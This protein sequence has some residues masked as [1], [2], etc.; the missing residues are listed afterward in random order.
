MRRIVL[1][2]SGITVF[3]CAPLPPVAFLPGADVEPPVITGLRLLSA[4]ELEVSFN[5]P[6][7]LVSGPRHP[8]SVALEEAVVEA[9]VLL[10]RFAEPP[11]PEHEHYVEAQVSDVAGNNLRFVV[12]FYGLNTLLPAMLI[13]EFITKHS[14]NHGEFVE[15]RIL[16]DG[17]LAGATL[18]EGI[19]GDWDQRFIF[20]SVDVVAGDYVVVHFRPQG[21]PEEV[22]E[23]VDR[24]ISGGRNASPDAWDFWVNGGTGLS[25]NNGVLTLCENPLG[26]YIDAVLYSNRTSDSD[27]RYRGFGSTRLMERADAIVTAGAW[28]AS[29]VTA[30]PEDAIDSGPSTATRSMSRASDGRDTNSRADWHI[31]PTRGS[32]P[33]G[34]NTDEVHVP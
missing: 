12:R 17:N 3:S 21:I 24:A 8:E 15:I 31:T 30:A 1:L 23:T 7:R 10:V 11:T 29:S 20:P 25:S 28:V 32:T 22:N 4:V 9:L 13:N 34:S 33:G 5:E 18:H 14:A 26:G 6:I 27:D 16:S 19:P 2:V